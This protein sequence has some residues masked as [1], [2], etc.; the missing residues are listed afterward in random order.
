MKAGFTGFFQEKPASRSMMRLMCFLT[1]L[2]AF[3]MTYAV[4]MSHIEAN[5]PISWVEFAILAILYVAA[6]APK[7]IQKFAESDALTNIIEKAV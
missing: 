1:L 2:F 3:I 4:I 6:Y 5:T 7:A